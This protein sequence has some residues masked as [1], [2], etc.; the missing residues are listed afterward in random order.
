MLYY[1]FVFQLILFLVLLCTFNSADKA[2]VE[3]IWKLVFLVS[4]I[5]A[6]AV[7]TFIPVA[8]EVIMWLR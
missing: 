1:Q 5:S 7:D 3:F 8:K 2:E 6:G 4:Y